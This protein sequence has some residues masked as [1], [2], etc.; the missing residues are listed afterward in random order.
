MREFLFSFRPVYTLC[1]WLFPQ[2]AGKALPCSVVLTANLDTHP[3][4][5]HDLVA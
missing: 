1:T 4:F 5:W 3:G 2:P